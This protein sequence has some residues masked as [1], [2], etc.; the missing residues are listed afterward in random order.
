MDF[1]ANKSGNPEGSGLVYG[2][3]AR[4]QPAPGQQHSMAQPCGMLHTSPGAPLSLPTTHRTRRMR[5]Q[6][7]ACGEQLGPT[8][9]PP[10]ALCTQ[11]GFSPGFKAKVAPASRRA[12]L[13]GVILKQPPREPPRGAASSTWDPAPA[14][15]APGWLQASL[16]RGWLSRGH[17]G[18]IC[19]NLCWHFI[20]HAIKWT[21]SEGWN[22]NL[23]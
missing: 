16:G 17:C 15:P 10:R 6:S 23:L 22:R 1:V 11:A 13:P 7:T 18:A 4:T 9:A 3:G 21:S 12:Q 20:S 5:P 19:S 2:F 8:P 14:L